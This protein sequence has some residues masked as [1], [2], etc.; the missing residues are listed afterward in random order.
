MMPFV[1]NRGVRTFYESIGE[2]ESIT[3]VHGS[4]MDGSVWKQAGYLD[5][6]RNYQC[7]LVDSR[8]SG[9]SDRPHTREAHTVDEHV[10]DVIQILDDLGIEK[11]IYW[12]YSIGGI[13]GYAVANQYPDRIKALVLAAAPFGFHG[14]LDTESFVGRTGRLGIQRWVE[15]YENEEHV[16]CPQWLK[17]TMCECDLEAWH[18]R[19]KAWDEWDFSTVTPSA[20]DI[21]TLLLVGTK[22]WVYGYV[23]RDAERLPRS[24]IFRL[25][26]EEHLGGLLRSDLTIPAAIEF[27]ST[28]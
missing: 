20:I 26:S 7:I 11:T 28:L 10:A 14:I 23:S 25:E 6:L 17:R 27:L 5:G 4:F 13:L 9:R 18:Q 3:F 15:E 1:Q 21:P 22:D 12:G 24:T 2:G 19:F 16:V 8:G